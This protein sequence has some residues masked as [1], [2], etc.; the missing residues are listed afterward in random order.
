MNEP[1]TKIH[2]GKLKQS[3]LEKFVEIYKEVG[4]NAI[5]FLPSVDSINED[6]KKLIEF[7]LTPNPFGE[8]NNKI[9]IGIR[10]HRKSGN[11]YIDTQ[12]HPGEQ[13]I[14]NPQELQLKYNELIRKYFLRE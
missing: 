3:D 9:L 10:Y 13:N 4:L 14:K 11:L 5:D 12:I 1:N 7:E 6:N 2:Y 8:A